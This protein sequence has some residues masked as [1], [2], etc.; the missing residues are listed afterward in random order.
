ME[1]DRNIVKTTQKIIKYPLKTALILTL[2]TAISCKSSDNIIIDNSKTSRKESIAIEKIFEEDFE[3]LPGEYQ[4]KYNTTAHK[5]IQMEKDF[6]ATTWDYLLLDILIE[7]EKAKIGKKRKYDTDEAISILQDIGKISRLFLTEPEESRNP[8]LSKCLENKL[9]DCDSLSLLCLS[10]GEE[11]NLP[12]QLAIVPWH[13]FIRLYTK[14]GPINW[15]VVMLDDNRIISDDKY[16][17]EENRGNWPKI[18][19]DKGIFA[20]HH[21]NRSSEWLNK[22]YYQEWQRNN[23]I[24]INR[25]EGLMYLK[26]GLEDT[27]KAIELFPEMFSAYYNKGEI[28]FC[29]GDYNK[30]LAAFEKADSLWHNEAKVLMWQG[31]NYYELCNYDKALELSTAAI[32]I[33]PILMKAY[34]LRSQIWHEKGDDEKALADLKMAINLMISGIR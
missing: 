21:T 11:I 15:D 12:M 22:Y 3:K 34:D 4:P 30:S 25:E 32:E 18:L 29:M 23:G 31:K 24:E 8:L 9:L 20:M 27:N 16:V 7:R 2:I 26:K 13:V 10:I 14:D 19:D 1:L 28:L 6:G 17:D 5:L 33:N